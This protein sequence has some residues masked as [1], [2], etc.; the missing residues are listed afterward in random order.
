MGEVELRSG[1]K[2][3]RYWPGIPKGV[4]HYG[5][6]IVA[7]AA[8]WAVREA[9]DPLLGNLQVFELFLAPVLLMGWWGRTGPAMLA[10]LLGLVVA[11]WF[12]CPPRGHL[13]LGEQ[14]VAAC[15]VYLIISTVLI[16]VTCQ[17]RNAR[18]RLEREVAERTKAEEELQRRARLIDLAP[19]G[20]IVRTP[21][22]TIRH[23]SNG[24]ERL[25]G[26]SKHE[27][28]GKRTHELLQTEFP[29]GLEKIVEKLR[30]VGK[31]SGELRHKTKD[32]RT[33][34]VESHWLGQF[35][36]GGEVT[37]LLESN[38]D[39]TGRKL[40]EEGLRKLT[41]ELELRVQQRTA[42]LTVA[43]KELEAFSYSVSHDLRAPLR[44]ID[45]FVKLLQKNAGPTLDEQNQRH[46]RIVMD[47]AARMG[48][49]IDDLLTFSRLGRTPMQE[50]PVRLGQLVEEARQELAHSMSGRTIEWH[51]ESLPR[52]NGDSTLL[53][54]VITNLL[55]NAIKYTRR[56]Q[57]ARIEVGSHLNDGQVVCFV[58]DNGAGFDMRFV[59]KLFGVF[60][61]LHAANEFEGNG[62]GLASVRRAIQRHGGRT[63]AESEVGKGATFYFS[64]P[65][66]RFIE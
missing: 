35:T 6:A 62:I 29:E 8:T 18:Q 10:A 44:H 20:T 11:D 31:W 51:V 25:Y 40:A 57:V 37:E 2:A 66:N 1:N 56:V 33:V 12:F 19:A 32:G 42:D 15:C 16:F 46:L 34:I 5:V 3:E 41:D 55:S 53:R 14:G 24:A 58:R 21:D 22:G 28:I 54:S 9:L 59:D 26:W 4:V 39:I 43:N 48:L 13:A 38:I 17:M 61:R 50:R 65:A 36:P 7:V 30:T 60:Q 27:A 52:V 47:A 63:W 64:L 23:W 45:S 49:L